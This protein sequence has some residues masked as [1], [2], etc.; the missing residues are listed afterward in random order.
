MELGSLLGFGI[1]AL[2]Q[3]FGRGHWEALSGFFQYLVSFWACG[4]DAGFGTSFRHLGCKI[5]W[6]NFLPIDDQPMEI[7]NPTNNSPVV[8]CHSRKKSSEPSSRKMGWRSFYR[9]R[10]RDTQGVANL[11]RRA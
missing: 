11:A 8:V 10:L 3:T 5:W 1:R 4:R 7:I 2:G 6:L 9:E